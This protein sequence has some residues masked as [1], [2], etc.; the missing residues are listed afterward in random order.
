MCTKIV[1]RK[2]FHV[3]TRGAKTHHLYIPVRILFSVYNYLYGV[4]YKLQARN[5]YPSPQR[6]VLSTP[7]LRH[8]DHL[9]LGIS[10]L[11]REQQPLVGQ[12]LI[13]KTTRS[14]TTTHHSR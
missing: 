6:K 11:P 3:R 12:G 10:P 2:C 13:I 4:I 9:E 1:C 14:H 5:S 8:D 7:E